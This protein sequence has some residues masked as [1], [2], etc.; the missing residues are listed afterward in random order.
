MQVG[1]GKIVGRVGNSWWVQVHDFSKTGDRLV[2]VVT[3]KRGGQE[4]EIEV[5]ERGREFLARLHELYY[6]SPNASA[7]ERLKKA[8]DRIMSEDS[9]VELVCAA[10]SGNIVY[11]VLNGGAVWTTLNNKEG[12]IF[13]N[14]KTDKPRFSNGRLQPGQTLL[15]GNGL[16]WDS[17]PQGMVRVAV[18]DNLALAVENLSAVV[19]GNEKEEGAS[20]LLLRLEDEVENVNHFEEKEETKETVVVPQIKNNFWDRFKRKDIYIGHELSLNSNHKLWLGVGALAFLVFSVVLGFWRKSGQDFRESLV[21][22]QL[23][24]VDFKFKEAQNVVS[25]NPT[26][27][28][29]LLVEV[30]DLLVQLKTQPDQKSVAQVISNIEKA[31]QFVYEK[32]IGV[33]RPETEEL[34]DLTLTRDGLKAD[35]MVFVDGKIIGLDVTNPRL[36]AVDPKKKSV[37]MMAGPVDLGRPLWLAGYPGKAVIGAEKSVVIC[38]AFQGSCSLKGMA[39]LVPSVL[40]AGMF[41]ANLYLLNT[42]GVWKY[43]GTDSGF[44]S[45]QTWLSEPDKLSLVGASS[46]S[47]DGN[48]WIIRGEEILKLT[49][50]VKQE[51]VLSGLD[52][53]WDKQTK[54]FTSEDNNN[55]YLWDKLNSRIVIIDKTGKYQSQIINDGLNK[56]QALVFDHV[57]KKIFLGIE[58]KI[59]TLKLLP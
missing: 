23:E 48:V 11:L 9:E 52:R 51:F 26:R 29:Q 27:S 8:V 56:A 37:Q 20:G 43:Q 54:I 57:N 45:K 5:V 14:Q 19:C 44:G 34:I 17:I 39:D 2:A 21:A 6:G 1:V 30:K 55:L 38:P 50:G 40:E 28:R 49:R 31:Y 24:A 35:N 7:Y 12:W 59:F 47:I 41:S 53:A 3:L 58:N 15:L 4:S 10:I 42:S 36:F 33:V 32:S 25:L 18:E 46:F 16:F 22:K 13:T